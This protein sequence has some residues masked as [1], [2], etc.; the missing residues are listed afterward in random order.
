MKSFF[1]KVLSDTLSGV[2][3]QIIVF[4]VVALWHGVG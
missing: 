2:L 3:V 1:L 4:A